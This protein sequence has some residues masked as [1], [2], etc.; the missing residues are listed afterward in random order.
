[1]GLCDTFGLQNNPATWD[2]GVL[3]EKYLGD[4]GLGISFL[5]LVE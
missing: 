4:H 1:M 2:S 3:D 5:L